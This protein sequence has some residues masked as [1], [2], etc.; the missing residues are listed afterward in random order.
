MNRWE[1]AQMGG[2]GHEWAGTGAKWA[3]KGANGR[4]PAVTWQ[5]LGSLSLVGGHM[6]VTWQL[7][8]LLSSVGGHAGVTWHRRR[9]LSGFVEVN[10]PALAWPI[11]GQSPGGPTAAVL[12]ARWWWQSK[13]Q[14]WSLSVVV[15]KGKKRATE[16]EPWLPDLAMAGL[17][18]PKKKHPLNKLNIR[19]K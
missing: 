16:N 10:G 18:D 13:W 11:T 15:V 6:G 9:R 12:A 7:V 1:G 3:G 19:I 2:K 17:R 5:L 4:E 8:G 14:G